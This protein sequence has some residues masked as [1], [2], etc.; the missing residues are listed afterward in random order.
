ME[1]AKESEMVAEPLSGNSAGNS[2][3]PPHIAN[4]IRPDEEIGAGILGPEDDLGWPTEEEIKARNERLSA[5]IDE[6][7]AECGPISEEAHEW[8]RTNLRLDSE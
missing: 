7:E 4:R 6:Y 3:A 1:R 2:E 8:V 5:V